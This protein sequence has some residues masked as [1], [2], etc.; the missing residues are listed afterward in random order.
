MSRVA[1]GASSADP[2]LGFI[3]RESTFLGQNAPEWKESGKL[4]DVDL[5]EYEVAS[6]AEALS[7]GRAEDVASLVEAL[8]S[9]SRGSA[10]RRQLCSPS[11]RYVC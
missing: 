10:D 1:T 6:A 5:G 8:A 9:S 2:G 11:P 4:V 3:A 7:S